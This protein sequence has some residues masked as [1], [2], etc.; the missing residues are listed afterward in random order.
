MPTILI[1]GSTGVVGQNAVRSLAAKPGVTVRAA[2]HTHPPEAERD[3]V[4]PVPVDYDK[5]ETVR[6]AAADVDAVFLITP[7]VPGQGAL[8]CR[9]VDVL[10]GAGVPRMVRLSVIGAD[11]P[12]AKFF[13]REH[14]EAESHIAASG[15]PCTL[16]RPGSF[17]S[18][19]LS[20][21]RPDPQGNMRMPL[22]NSGC[23]YID[24]RDIGDVA[25]EVLTNDG[26]IGKAY[27][28]TGPEAITM[29]QVAA[30][31][32]DVSGRPIRY[33]DTP[34][35]AVRQGML[36]HGVPPP[37]VEG[38]MDLFAD[39]KAGKVSLV[40]G[41]VQELTSRPARSFAEF[42][43]DYAQAWMEK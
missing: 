37:M 13:L 18:N 22:G 11:R 9:M 31:I 7:P 16:L 5:P 38:I 35:E 8:A 24:P 40:T 39:Q 4:Q 30:A 14:A 34:E 21:F 10:K 6:A 43:R 17:M 28:L 3:N 29:S 2:F 27:T 12:D 36:A 19:F 33:I 15:I 26:H 41:A 1:T 32:S 42:A 20:F 23:S 25:A